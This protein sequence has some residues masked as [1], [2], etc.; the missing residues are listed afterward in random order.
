MLFVLGGTGRMIAQRGGPGVDALIGTTRYD[1]G[2][3]FRTISTARFDIYFHQ[4]EEALARRLAGLVEAVAADVDARLG[5]PHGRVH[6]ILVDQTDQSNGWATVFPYN[7]IELA[8]VPP[9]SQST[10]GNTRD[11]LR[12]VFAHEYTHVVHLEKTRGW[13]GGLRHVFGRLPVLQPNV[14]LPQWQVEGIATYEEGIAAAGGRVPAGDFRMI[15]DSAA[16]EHRFAPLDRA[17]GGVVDWPSGNAPYVYGAYFHDYLARRYGPESLARLAEQTAGTLPYFGSRAFRTV[18]GRSLGALWKD[19]EEDT[20]SRVSVERDPVHATRL[21]RHGFFVAGPS[22]S[23]GGHL[24]YSVVNPH[25][26][27]AVMELPLGPGARPRQ[28]ASRYLGDRLSATRDVLV[29]DQQEIVHHADLQSD[30]YVV[31]LDGGAT[32]RITKEARAADP[33][34]APDGHT[35]VCTVQM[36]GLRAL[37]MLQMPADGAF[38]AALPFISEES[39]DFSAPRWSPDGRFIAAERRRLGGPSEI[40]VIDVT[41]RDVRTLTSSAR[42]RNVGPLWLPDG[43]TILFSSDR[44]GGPFRIYG[45]DVATGRVRRLL[46]TGPAQFP[47]LSPEGHQLVFVGYSADGYDLYSLPFDAPEWSTPLAGVAPD[48]RAVGDADATGGSAG[49]PS[50]KPYRPWSTLAPRYW[51]PVVESRRDDT[52]VGASTSGFDALGRHAY[53]VTGTWAVP[54]DRANWEAD[55]AYSRWWPTFFAGAS[56]TLDDWR[57]GDVHTRELRAGAL[58]PVRRV[59]W[60][61]TALAALQASR[62]EFDCPSCEPAVRGTASIA[63]MQLGWNLS[64][65]KS[66]GYSI[67]A[68]QGGSVGVT[69]ELRRGR[70]GSDATAGAATADVRGY[71]R[72]L[73]RHGVL[74]VRT[75]AATTWGDP[76]IRRVFEAG[77][78][79]PQGGGFAFGSGA[80]GLLRGFGTADL[81]GFHAA[82]LNIDYRF[83]LA[84]PQRGFG[85]VPVMLRNVHGALFTDAGSAW[86]ESFRRAD[87]RR[88]FGAELS[89][90]TVLGDV[91]ALTVTGGAAWRV[92]PSGRRGGWTAFARAG[93]AF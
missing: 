10:I 3:R 62:D 4:R 36:T 31:P 92:D 1:P 34:I 26:F 52:L 8:A 13:I 42:G 93:R 91:L 46:G 18:F 89:S 44:E 41:T 5:A 57:S 86:D 6:V 81:Y 24:Y 39:T 17:G 75:A 14:F 27:P 51:S 61:T 76:G 43:L 82:V 88:A 56:D 7:L 22:F 15:L 40:V 50:G 37:A 20:T 49:P 79:G 28:V 35:L 53:V 63:A 55:Y 54:R 9:E 84:W 80:V 30:L 19:F 21:T 60:R 16:A 38:A 87:V 72:A 48:E 45:A 67:S 59:R 12:T 29:F 58:L 68:E 32:R 77:G 66:F 65:A 64:S 23:P 90:D 33:D 71:V 69:T 11:W 74:A 78:S 73:P 70:A 25:G 83:P 2:L 47:T 85:T